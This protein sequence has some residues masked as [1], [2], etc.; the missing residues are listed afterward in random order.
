M[1]G[2]RVSV[3]FDFGTLS[4]RAT[5]V[6]VDNGEALASAASAYA[7][8]EIAG[9]LEGAGGRIVPLAPECVLQDPDDWLPAAGSALR[10]A[11]ASVGV[12]LCGSPTPGGSDAAKPTAHVVGL[13]VAFT[14]CTVLPCAIDGTPLCRMSSDGGVDW[15]ARPHAYPKL[16]KSHSATAACEHLNAVARHRRERWLAR[17]G[18]SVGVEWL[19]P[20]L[21]EVLTA[22][23]AAYDAMEVFLEAGDWFVW[24][25]VGGPYRAR[26]GDAS[27]PLRSACQ[28]GYKACYGPMGPRGGDATADAGGGDC[29]DGYPSREFLAAVHPRLANAVE[30]KLAG[31]VVPPGARAGA[32]TAEAAAALGFAALEGVPVA[33]GES[34]RRLECPGEVSC[35]KW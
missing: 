32:L 2:R 23:P 20:K 10:A 17:Y 11:V 15:S 12:E 14:S 6:D 24:Q 25:L 1:A 34:W 19:W 28:A 4:V 7:H 35:C 5:L 13:G 31:A 30:E 27:A 29:G 16:W 21:L 33:A 18:G 8:G 9:T 26:R 3:G 22:D